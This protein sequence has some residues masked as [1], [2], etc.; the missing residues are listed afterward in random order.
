[1][2]I[3]D[4]SSDQPCSMP[5]GVDKALTAMTGAA[6]NLGSL[7]AC[8]ELQTDFVS[9]LS[10]SVSSGIGKLSAL[11]TQQKLTIQLLSIANSLSQNVL[12]LFR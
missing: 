9:K 3:S 8:I 5:K 11:R 7:S 1:M 12:S 2:D 4:M 10:D 6:A